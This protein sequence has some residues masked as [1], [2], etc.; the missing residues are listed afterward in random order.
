[1]ELIFWNRAWKH[2]L[3][4]FTQHSWKL[5][6]WHLTGIGQ[7]DMSAHGFQSEAWRAKRQWQMIHS[8]GWAWGQQNHPNLLAT[9]PA[10]RPVTQDCP[11]G[12]I[13]PEF[14]APLLLLVS[15][16]SLID[17]NDRSDTREKP[18]HRVTLRAKHRLTPWGLSL[19]CVWMGE[20]LK[21]ENIF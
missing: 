14:L 2:Q 4:A 17:L 1:M 18:R 5:R 7:L 13:L 8:Y 3:L 12:M 15:A 10:A 9:R 11:C 16:Y 21:R 6:S 20:D 19:V